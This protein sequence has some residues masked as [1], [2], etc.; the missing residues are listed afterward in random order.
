[1]PADLSEDENAASEEPQAPKRTGRP[2]KASQS[3]ANEKAAGSRPKKGT[4]KPNFGSMKANENGR[5]FQP[6][7]VV[8]WL[9]FIVPKG[10][11]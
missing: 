2:K 6:H 5:L 11:I 10:V 1:M 9:K 3:N 8:I 4:Q 7:V